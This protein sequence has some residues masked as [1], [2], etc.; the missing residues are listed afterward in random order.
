MKNKFVQPN[1][2]KFSYISYFVHSQIYKLIFLVLMFLLPLYL[3]SKEFLLLKEKPILMIFWWIVEFVIVIFWAFEWAKYSTSSFTVEKGNIVYK[4]KKPNNNAPQD[5]RGKWTLD[6]CYRIKNISKVKVYFNSIVIY[7]DIKKEI[8]NYYGAGRSVH[9]RSRN[10][11][12]L[13][14][15]KCFKNNRELVQKL[16]DY[17]K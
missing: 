8:S 12:R 16:S 17:N 5:E 4:H 14:V 10:K 2:Y 1:T 15:V 6:V 3:R 11:K 7:G 9:Y 13:R